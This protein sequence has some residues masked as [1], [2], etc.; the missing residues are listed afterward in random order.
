M[1]RGEGGREGGREGGGEGEKREGGREGR[2]RE[3]RGREGKDVPHF[4]LEFCLWNFL[5]SLHAWV[6]LFLII[7]VLF[8]LFIIGQ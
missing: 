1:G 3:R 5:C 8:Y 2:G 7:I 4:L 6:Y